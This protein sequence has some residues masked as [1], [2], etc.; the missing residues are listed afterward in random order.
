MLDVL[1]SIPIA[2]GYLTDPLAL[3]YSVDDCHTSNCTNIPVKKYNLSSGQCKYAYKFAKFWDTIPE[4][5]QKA[6][7][8]EMF[9]THILKLSHERCTHMQAFHDRYV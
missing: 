6:N 5:I 4:C 2:P 3:N 8:V 1:S 9:K 7:S